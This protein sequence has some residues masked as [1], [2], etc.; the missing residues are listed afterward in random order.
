[1]INQA[2]NLFQ[3]NGVYGNCLTSP[4]KGIHNGFASQIKES[5][6]VRYVAIKIA[7]LTFGTAGML[8]SSPFAA[9]GMGIKLVDS[10][11]HRGRNNRMRNEIKKYNSSFQV[12]KR[13]TVSYLKA[14]HGFSTLQEAHEFLQKQWGPTGIHVISSSPL[15]VTVYTY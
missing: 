15:K 12:E 6:G 2:F 10:L 1:M 3:D 8:F 4:M 7:Q 11:R 9:V 5:S 14:N 13:D